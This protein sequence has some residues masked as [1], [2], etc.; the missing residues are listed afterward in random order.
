MADL[1]CDHEQ[2]ATH[3]FLHAKYIA[4][5]SGSQRIVISF[6]D[7]NMAVIGV[8]VA[9]ML[10]STEL[11]WLT[12]TG[13]RRRY[14]NLS[15]ICHCLNSKVVG[16]LSGFHSLTGCNSTSS[17]SGKGK[18]TV[19]RMLVGN[20]V[21]QEVCSLVG[22]AIPLAEELFQLC[23]QLVSTLYGHPSSS[24]VNHIHYNIFRKN[25]PISCRT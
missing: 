19:F 23:E 24:S 6:P 17:F 7:T 11:L 12:G 22:Q 20:N 3:M 8:Y 4:V 9:S 13:R 18:K 14:V 21:A 1:E 2:A 5:T 10:T 25:N 16:A 15:K